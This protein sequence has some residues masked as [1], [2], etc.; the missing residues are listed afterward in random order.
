MKEETDGTGFLWT[1][2]AYLKDYLI[3]IPAHN[4]GFPLSHTYRTRIVTLIANEVFLIPPW[5][6]V[7]SEVFFIIRPNIDRSHELEL[8]GN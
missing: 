7:D 4:L 5:T 1:E 2:S 8:A 6:S 3:Y